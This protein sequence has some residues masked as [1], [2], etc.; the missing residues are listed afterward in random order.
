MFNFIWCL[1]LHDSK[2]VSLVQ[3]F[4]QSLHYFGHAPFLW[5]VFEPFCCHCSTIV[6]VRFIGYGFETKW[7]IWLCIRKQYGPSSSFGDEIYALTFKSVM[8]RVDISTIS[9]Y[10]KVLLYIFAHITSYMLDTGLLIHRQV[11]VAGC[12]INTELISQR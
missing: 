10:G 1:R 3:P 7:K 6:N 2:W 9:L 12:V 5:L 8:V 11:I 4:V